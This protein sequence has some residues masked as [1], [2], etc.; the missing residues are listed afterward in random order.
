MIKGQSSLVQTL[1][2]ITAKVR[3]AAILFLKRVVGNLMRKGHMR[4]S[5]NRARRREGL[6]ETW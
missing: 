4:K 2:V 6:K 1:V 5:D 3:I